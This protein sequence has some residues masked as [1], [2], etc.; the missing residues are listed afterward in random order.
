LKFGTEEL[1][2]YANR[3]FD[4]KRVTTTNLPPDSVGFSGELWAH[5]VANLAYLSL[6]LHREL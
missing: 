2:T 6:M 4:K 5:H 3:L 1:N